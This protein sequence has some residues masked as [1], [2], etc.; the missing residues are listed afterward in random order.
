MFCETNCN[1]GTGF[2]KKNSPVYTSWQVHRQKKGQQVLSSIAMRVM[3]IKIQDLNRE[4]QVNKIVL[5]R[6]NINPGKER[7]SGD[8]ECQCVKLW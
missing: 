7:V 6:L 8:A 2:G 5:P 4:L 3:H 1:L